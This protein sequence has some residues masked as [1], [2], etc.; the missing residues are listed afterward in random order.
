MDVSIRDYIG[1]EKELT[2][3]QV[4]KLPEGTTVRLHSFDRH[5]EHVYR[6]MTIVRSGKK[7]ILSSWDYWDGGRTTKDIKKETDRFCYTEVN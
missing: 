1:R 5:G 6:D 7:K 3:E 2:A 4:R